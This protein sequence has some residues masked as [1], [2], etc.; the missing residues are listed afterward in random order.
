MKGLTVALTIIAVAFS[1]SITLTM[2]KEPERNLR[3]TD[4]EKNWVTVFEYSNQSDYFDSALVVE[5]QDDREQ[6]HRKM[7]TH[8][9]SHQSFHRGVI[10][11]KTTGSVNISI[12]PAIIRIESDYPLCRLMQVLPF[13]TTRDDADYS[14]IGTCQHEQS[15]EDASTLST[16]PP[17]RMSFWI[18]TLEKPTTPKVFPIFSPIMRESR[19]VSTLASSVISISS[20]SPDNYWYSN[21]MKID[22]IDEKYLLSKRLKVVYLTACHDDIF[23]LFESDHYPMLISST[24]HHMTG[25]GGCP[26][27]ALMNPFEHKLV[28]RDYGLEPTIFGF[29]LPH[30]PHRRARKD[31]LPYQGPFQKI[32][33]SPHL[34]TG[35]A[36]CMNFREISRRLQS[37]VQKRS[38]DE[39]SI[40][41][42]NFALSPFSLC[43]IRVDEF[44]EFL[45]VCE[46]SGVDIIAIWPFVMRVC[47]W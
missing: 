27:S 40:V 30:V 4:S 19:H 41:V 16:T 47:S 13:F 45:D 25:R 38:Q 42:L 3:Q 17:I 2:W 34:Y 31:S 32:R 11:N 6:K 21:A 26:S 7:K 15:S 20:P 29:L 22:R 24:L 35:W 23:S 5:V 46:K 14:C 10:T 37:H 12:V 36:D 18:D 9:K 33:D 28:H 1:V 44:L 39:I 43:N 8:P